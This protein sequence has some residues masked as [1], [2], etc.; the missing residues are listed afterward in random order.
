MRSAHPLFRDYKIT[1]ILCETVYICFEFRDKKIW[2]LKVLPHPP[3]NAYTNYPLKERCLYLPILRATL[4]QSY[5]L[6]CQ[7]VLV[8]YQEMPPVKKCLRWVCSCA[9]T[10]VNPAYMLISLCDVN[11]V[12]V[13]IVW[14]IL[15]CYA[16]SRGRMYRFC[17][18]VAGGVSHLLH[19]GFSVINGRFWL[20][21]RAG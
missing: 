15:R 2:F 16:N 10:I 20:C 12:H 21:L 1:L 19:C 17:L 6:L 8:S 9:V 7:P 18:A 5:D 14:G 3:S 4:V 13:H 11:A